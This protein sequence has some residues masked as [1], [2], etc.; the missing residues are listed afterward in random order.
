V[1]RTALAAAEEAA[2]ALEWTARKV[3]AE[4]MASAVA[5]A[6]AEAVAVARTE[7]REASWMKFADKLIA[8]IELGGNA[9]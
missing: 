8:L 2:E 1:A 4:A 5:Q 7:A 6:M 9:G 3:M